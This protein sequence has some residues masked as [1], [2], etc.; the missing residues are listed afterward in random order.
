MSA[1]TGRLLAA[2]VL[3]LAVLAL[4]PG[5]RPVR[6]RPMA[7]QARPRRSWPSGTGRCCS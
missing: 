2:A 5:L 1:R 7:H 3:L 4:L 6:R